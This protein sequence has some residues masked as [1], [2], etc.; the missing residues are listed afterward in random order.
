MPAQQY[1]YP[2]KG[3]KPDQLFWLV[4]IAFSRI[5]AAEVGFSRP[6]PTWRLFMAHRLPLA[7]GRYIAY[8]WR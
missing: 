5:P 1:M 2:A 3:K 4:G 6:V 7:V 8:P